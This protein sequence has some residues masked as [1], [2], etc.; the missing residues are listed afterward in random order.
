M[1]NRKFIVLGG[2][3]GFVVLLFIPFLL[4]AL[5]RGCG[6][7]GTPQNT[8]ANTRPVAAETKKVVIW[9]LY[10][11]P[12]LYQGIFQD[13]YGK[14]P[15]FVIEYH[16]FTDINE[17]RDL[18]IN[19][20]AE[21]KGPDIAMIQNTWLLKD[22]NKFSPFPVGLREMSPDVFRKTFVDV[23]ADDLIVK[24]ENGEEQIYGFP[25]S[26]DTL[27]LYYNKKD[28]RDYVLSSTLPSEIWSS[29]SGNDIISQVVKMNKP[30][31]SF[32]RFQLSGMGMGRSDNITKAVDVLSLLMLQF[33]TKLYD[34]E[35]MRI[36]TLPNSTGVDPEKNEAIYPA[37]NALQ[38]FTSFA[39][40][41]YKH[42]SWNELITKKEAGEEEIGAFASGK[43][44]MIFG[45]SY[46]LEQ[47]KDSIKSKKDRGKQTISEDDVGITVIPQVTDKVGRVAFASYYPFV[48]T[49]TSQYKDEAWDL[50]LDLVDEKAQELYF[51]KAHKPTSRPAMI[52]RQSPDPVY[53]IFALQASYAQSLKLVD[54]FR[55]REIFNQMISDVVNGRS[56]V[57]KSISDANTKLQCLLDQYNKLPG[58]EAVN[59]L[60]EKQPTTGNPGS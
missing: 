17:Y 19:E 36:S 18:L 27:G 6:G 46:T 49:N 32:E 53:G 24:D 28:F 39:L 35:T 50:I 58:K 31:L 12:E 15:G 52:D 9:G 11:D 29:P 14:H 16:K 20:I 22:K 38:L 30:D 47:I 4:S 13:F 26:V 5:L 51:S 23:A 1:E 48:V 8:N 43:V 60:N 3:A 56:D 21:G 57:R 25:T 41:D 40:P 54:P 34:D 45:Y 7:G 10:D 2:L 33:G 55:A 44:A 42:Y 37:L 59:C